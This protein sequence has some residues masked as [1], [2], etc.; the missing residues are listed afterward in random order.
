[1][2]GW[3]MDWWLDIDLFHPLDKQTCIEG[4]EVSFISLV[5]SLNHNM[6]HIYQPLTSDQSLN[7]QFSWPSA[8][9][10]AAKLVQFRNNFSFLEITRWEI[11]DL[12]FLIYLAGNKAAISH[13]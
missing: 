8:L 1:M 7:R 10:S 11:F 4:T 12:H 6:L 2:H 9:L 13:N 3:R 5:P